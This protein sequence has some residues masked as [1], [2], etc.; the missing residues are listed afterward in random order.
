MTVA[1]IEH[2]KKPL[3]MTQLS[4]VVAEWRRRNIRRFAVQMK[5]GRAQPVEDLFY[6]VS[7]PSI[8]ADVTEDTMF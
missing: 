1:E 6:L 3:R 4:Y 5:Y 2:A 7:T 8:S